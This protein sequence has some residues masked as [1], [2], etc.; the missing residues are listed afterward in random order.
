[1]V[2]YF[3][4]IMPMRSQIFLAIALLRSS[5]AALCSNYNQIVCNNRVELNCFCKWHVENGVCER[6]NDCHNE[7]FGTTSI[8]VTP[9]CPSIQIVWNNTQKDICCQGVVDCVKF[10]ETNNCST[11]EL[12]S[13]D[14][15]IGCRCCSVNW[16]QGYEDLQGQW[17]TARLSSDTDAIDNTTTTNGNSSCPS[18]ENYWRKTQKDMCCEG[19]DCVA[20][21]KTNNCMTRE[22]WSTEKEIGCRCCG[23]NWTQGYEDVQGQWRTARFSSDADDTTTTTIAITTVAFARAKVESICSIMVVAIMLSAS[24]SLWN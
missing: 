1:M 2:S 4:P 9:R 3:Q 23:I 5:Y 24:F 22:L 20:F 17:R 7:S 11:R 14:K 6:S 18:I 16:A 21:N 19:I 13:T 10:N 15:E 12:W 8:S